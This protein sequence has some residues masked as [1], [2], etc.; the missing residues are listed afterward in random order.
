MSASP[1]EFRSA[2]RLSLLG[3]RSSTTTRAI[4]VLL[5]VSSMA[6]VMGL[7]WRVQIQVTTTESLR[8]KASDMQAEMASLTQAPATPTASGRQRAAGLQDSARLAL[9]VDLLNTPWLD[10]LQALEQHTPDDVAVLAI[11]PG[12]RGNIRIQAE[13]PKLDRLLAHATD[14]QD[15]GPFGKLSLRRHETNEK[16]SNQPARLSFELH[17]A[18]GARP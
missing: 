12:G 11:E 3:A 10:I 13:S 16:D 17:L 7:A 9:A 1:S 18:A 6:L 4:A 14:L 8:L 5:L 15:T 2:T